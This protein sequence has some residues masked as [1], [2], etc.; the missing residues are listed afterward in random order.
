MRIPTAA[1]VGTCLLACLTQ[2]HEL[3]T[4]EKAVKDIQKKELENVLW[5]LQKIA[6]DN[7]GNRAHGYPGYRASVDFVLER[8][9]KRFGARL[10]TYV[11]EFNHTFSQV[12]KISLTGPNKEKVDVYALLFLQ[13]T[14]LP[15]GVTAPLLDTPVDDVVGS[16]CQA[17]AWCPGGGP[18]P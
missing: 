17:R 7:G 15:D 18:L 10:D 5:N 13:S 16:M 11:Q 1:A 12:R 2:A 3:I 14:P 9:S 8:V 4:P 6:R